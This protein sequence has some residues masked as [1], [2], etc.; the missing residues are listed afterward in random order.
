MRRTSGLLGIVVR[1]GCR[2]G[3]APAAGSSVLGCLPGS[4]V[5]L[6][7]GLRPS[8]A[9]TTRGSRGTAQLVVAV[10]TSPSKSIPAEREAIMKRVVIGVEPHKLSATIELVDAAHRRNNPDPARHRGSCLVPTHARRRQDPDGGH[11]LNSSDGPPT[12]E[13]RQL[14]ARCSRRRNADVGPGPEG[15]AGATQ[16][17]SAADLVACPVDDLC[18]IRLAASA[19][20]GRPRCGWD[21]AALSPYP[22]RLVADRL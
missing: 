21:V 12:A 6:Y 9:V 13:Y 7:S 18:S 14:I 2:A 15:T 10:P 19:R 22:T 5:S 20:S 3:L 17:S 1:T 4:G 11:A 16:K 8:G